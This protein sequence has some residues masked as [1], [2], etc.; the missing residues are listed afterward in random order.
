MLKFFRKIRQKILAEGNLK[1]Y[2]IY[3]TGEILLDMIDDIKAEDTLIEKPD[4]N[5]GL[6]TEEEPSIT[7]YKS[8]QFI[9]PR[10][11]QAY[12]TVVSGVLKNSMRKVLCTLHSTPTSA[13]CIFPEVLSL[14]AL[15]VVLFGTEAT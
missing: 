10:D 8:G 4:N 14:L 2:L 5:Q 12:R 13:N 7:S 3:A 11:G 15:P 9:D 1:K 6:I